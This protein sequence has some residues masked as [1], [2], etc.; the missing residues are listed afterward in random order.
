MTR[1][2]VF[3]TIA[4][5]VVGIDER[6]IMGHSRDEMI[7]LRIIDGNLSAAVGDAPQVVRVQTRGM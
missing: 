2:A 5:A 3:F 6:D 1:D 4:T 7:W